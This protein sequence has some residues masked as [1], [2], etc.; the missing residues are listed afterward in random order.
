[1][2]INKKQKKIIIAGIVVFI[3]AGLFPPWIYTLHVQ[4]F[5][6]EK[7]AEYAL[8]FYPPDT[9]EYDPEYGV[10]L[11]FSRLAVQWLVVIA[12]TGLGV[13]LASKERITQQ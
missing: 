13:L 7:P 6:T 12:A 10:E 4:A 5:D 11:D 2:T 8:I 3:L 9:E 1:M